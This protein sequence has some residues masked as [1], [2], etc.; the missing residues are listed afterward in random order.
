[1]AILVQNN[2]SFE[3][4]CT[5]HWK[6]FSDLR[7]TKRITVQL[8]VD[9]TNILRAAFTIADPKS[10][11]KL[12]DLTVFFALLVSAGVKAARR[13]LMKLTPVFQKQNFFLESNL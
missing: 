4:D 6:A 3:L 12:L 11:K 1:M 5:T 8:G 9:F 7:H 10:T 2:N 13:M